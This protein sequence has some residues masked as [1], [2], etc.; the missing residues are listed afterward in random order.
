MRI[1][2]LEDDPSQGELLSYWLKLGGHQSCVFT[3][4]QALLNGLAETKF[5]TL[6]LD[7]NI[8]DLSGIDVLRQVRRKSAIP[9][10]FCTSKDQEED[11]ALALGE[12]A[13]DYCIKPMRRLELLARLDSVSRRSS[14]MPVTSEW[15]EV[16]DVRINCQNRTAMRG[17]AVVP[18]SC[19]QFD[20]AVLLLS[21]VGRS[22]TRSEIFK[23]VFPGVSSNSRTLDTHI[24]SVRSK[25]GL[26]AEQGWCL[27]AVYGQGY[28]L[29]R[30]TRLVTRKQAEYACN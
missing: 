11:V 17:S 3:R 23:T 19:K 28:R 22:L 14:E 13:D 2:I 16:G 6:V 21:N 10:L 4:G 24:A 15:L 8:P 9:V 7:W 25:L 30:L 12:G 29:Q 20:L 26:V 18:L 5:D 27:T 1:A